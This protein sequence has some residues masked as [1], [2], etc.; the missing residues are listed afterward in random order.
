[1]CMYLQKSVRTSE[2]DC[3]WGRERGYRHK[4]QGFTHLASR[5]LGGEDTRQIKIYDGEGSIAIYNST[6]QWLAYG[7]GEEVFTGLQGS[8]H[9]CPSWLLWEEN[10]NPSL[11][12]YDMRPP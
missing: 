12:L 8:L 1:M 3:R 10:M 6:P 4:S 11:R 2:R 7:G 5:R 9:L